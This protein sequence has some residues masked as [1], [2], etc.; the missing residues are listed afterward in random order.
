MVLITAR[1][2]Q[3]MTLFE[4]TLT[5]NETTLT[6]D[7]YCGFMRQNDICAR[8]AAYISHYCFSQEEDGLLKYWWTIPELPSFST[9]IP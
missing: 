1:C 2:L 8:G 3:S 4:S 5:V 9:N 7:L 6:R